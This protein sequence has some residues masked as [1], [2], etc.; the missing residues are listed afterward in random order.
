MAIEAVT[1]RRVALAVTFSAV[2]L[3]IVILTAPLFGSSRIDLLRAFQGEW[4]HHEI[5]FRARL[6][7]VLLAVLSGGALAL[8]GVLFQAMLR[9]PLATPYTLGVSAGASLGAVTA[10]S[11]GWRMVA[12]MPAIWAASFAGAFL[13]LLIVLGLAAEGRRISSF[14]LLLSGV[15]INSIAI[16]LIMLLHSMATFGQSFTITRW[17]LG[18][19]DSLDYP[20]LLVLAL[21]IVPVSVFVFLQ[22]RHWN[23]M[24]VGEE[25]AVSR[26]AAPNRLL[27]GGYIAGSLLTAAVTGITGP[28]GF[29]GLVVPHALRLRLGADHRILMPCAFLLGAAFLA[30]CDLASRTF[31]AEEGVPVGVLTA[32]IGGPW[33]I[34]MLRSRKKSLW[35]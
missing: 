14:T 17:M 27:I 28:I 19:L 9:D 2:F 20:T 16:A 33:L 29:V 3:L 22:A 24:A 23:L 11:F 32:L 26:G 10:I 21:L 25:W 13:T 18:G 7:R 15:T 34:A 35:L 5:F 6:P 31:F 8:A 12:G 4:P 30:I 1:P